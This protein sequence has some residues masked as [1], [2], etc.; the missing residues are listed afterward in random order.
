MANPAKPAKESKWFRICTA[1]DTADGREISETDIQQAADSYKP[2]TYGARVNME[3][4]RGYTP[5]SPFRMYGD[6][7]AL[8]AEKVDGKLRLFA[9]IAPTD[10]LVAMVNVMKQKVYTSCEFQPNFAKTGG[11]YLVGL[12]VTDSPASLGTEMLQFSAG[13]GDKGPLTGRK[14]HK[15]NL[16]SVAQEATIEFTD[17]TTGDGVNLLTS[18]INALTSLAEKFSKPP[19][20]IKPVEK[21]AD[22]VAGE[23][24]I[25]VAKFMTET[26]KV[27]GEVSAAMVPKSDFDNLQE[28][29]TALDKQFGELKTRLEEETGSNY[30]ARPAAT[31]GD[32]NGYLQTDC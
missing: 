2:D 25:E 26:A 1:G 7:L 14:Q 22:V 27:L 29:F 32:A 16:F 10:D 28:K 30:T 12:A 19:E 23:T 13:L 15:D 11:T 20:A 6:V 17:V 8:K 3:H 18:A 31:G 21:I 5:D 9:Q 4:I 24:N